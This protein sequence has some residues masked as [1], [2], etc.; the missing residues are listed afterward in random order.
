MPASPP[1]LLVFIDTNLITSTEA[2]LAINVIHRSLLLIRENC[3]AANTVH[4]KREENAV[5]I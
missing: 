4:H 5:C 1:P 3:T 2:L